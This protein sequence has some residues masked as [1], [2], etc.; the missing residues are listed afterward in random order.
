[1]QLFKQYSNQIFLSIISTLLF[2]VAGCANSNNNTVTDSLAPSVISTTP[3]SD[4]T[5]INL[6]SNITI[7]FSEALDSTTLTSDNVILTKD[8]VAVSADISY[9]DKVVTFTPS[10]DLDLSTIYTMTITTKVTDL[11]RNGM[12]LDYSWSFTTK[13]EDIEVIRD[14]TPP[15]ITSTSPINSELDIPLN[16]SIS[17]IFSEPLDSNSVTSSS[18]TLVSLVDSIN[19]NGTTKYTGNTISFKPEANLSLDTQYRAT[20]T[21]SVKDLAN[22]TMESDYNW[23]FTT[24]A[25]VDTTPQSITSTEILDGQ[26]DVVKSSNIS[27][28]FNEPLDVT[29]LTSDNVILTK[30]GVAVSGAVSY[31]GNTMTFNPNSDMDASSNYIMTITTRVK[32]LA[33]NSMATDYTLS[34][35]T[36]AI[37]D[38]TAPKITSIDPFN[39]KTNVPSNINIS[40]VFSE[41]LDSNS[42]TDSSFTLVS[43]VDDTNINGL[44]SYSANTMSFNPEVNLSKDREYRATITTSIKDLAGNAMESDYIWSFTTEATIDTTPPSVVSIEPLDNKIGVARNSNI[45]AI[46]SEA[47]NSSSFN[48]DTFTLSTVG[49]RDINGSMSYIG[50]TMSF[51][52]EANLS[53][54]TQYRATITTSI[55]DLANNSMESDYIWSFTTSAI[56][57]TT[58]QSITSINIVDG[59]VGVINDSN[60][61]MIFNEA[62]DPTTVTLANITLTKDGIPV[63]GTLSYSG[64]EITFNPN[65]DMDASTIYTMTITT[66]V[67][68]LSGNSMATDYT[69]SFT[70]GAILD[71]TPPIVISID[72]FNTQI[73]VPLNR[74]ISAV[75]SEP[76]DSNSFTSSSFTLVPSMGGEDIN[77]TTSYADSIMTF[78]PKLN[79]SSDTEYNAT[80]TTYI[81]DLNGNTMLADYRWSFRTGAITTSLLAPVNL[82][83]AGDF[84]ILAKSG[85]S[86]TGTTAITGDMGVSPIDLTAITGFAYTLAGTY[87]TSGLVEGKIYAANMTPPT[88]TNLTTSIS[89]METAYTDAAGRTIPDYTNLG[90]GDVSGM[91]LSAGLYKW[92]TS[93]NIDNRGVTISGGVNDV[94]IFQISGDLTLASGSI[95]TLAGGALP[96]NIFWQVAGG[97]GV[98]L[99]TTSQ[100]KGIALTQ[101]AIVVKT[102]ATVNGRLLSQKAVTLDANAVVKP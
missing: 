45:S 99:G 54:D 101:A 57:D 73:D 8:G 23:S 53:A 11:V 25:T 42:F 98:S 48:A 90:A 2:L 68:D 95:I 20:I 38:K 69:L 77:G 49:G 93:L 30:D 32:D 84:V 85:I 62:L 64:N 74:S 61:T 71:S 97:A 70:T 39:S 102:G 7:T 9:R 12:E 76:L 4:A 59:A 44:V 35:T 36:E 28:V 89:N 82:G 55:K 17:A 27:V 40:A 22:N 46:F 65:S 37:I 79:L 58:P 43:T 66:R 41:P 51:N 10:S 81:A 29:T 60:I 26:V 75:F 34:F 31:D 96:K 100:F 47:L 80:L 67:K 6:S 92:G 13:A 56:L 63:S 52:P 86:T 33:G 91:T 18:F 94:W 16:R 5:D 14:T 88:P 87:A 1:M 72:P 24:G 3:M 83:M 50:N 21:T 78:N 19:I 15:I